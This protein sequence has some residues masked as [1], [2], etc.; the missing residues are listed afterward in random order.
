MSQCHNSAAV[1]AARIAYS[2]SKILTTGGL[3]SEFFYPNPKLAASGQLVLARDAGLPGNFR[4]LSDRHFWC[5]C[6]AGIEHTANRSTASARA[7]KASTAFCRHAVVAHCTSR[8]LPPALR[9]CQVSTDSAVQIRLVGGS[10][11]SGQL[12]RHIQRSRWVRA[13]LPCCLFHFSS[14]SILPFPFVSPSLRPFAVHP[15]PIIT[16]FLLLSIQINFFFNAVEKID[17]AGHPRRRTV[18][19]RAGDRV[20]SR[21]RRRRVDRGLGRQATRACRAFRRRRVPHATAGDFDDALA[22]SS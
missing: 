15:R 9:Y 7:Q 8:T 16:S 6:G 1:H 22:N 5:M 10:F 19:I 12:Q 3:Y 21:R 14:H 18:R 11:V 13:S 17:G 4:K 20:Q 2:G